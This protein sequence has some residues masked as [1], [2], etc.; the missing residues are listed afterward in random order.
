[1]GGK[2]QNSHGQTQGEAGLM[3]GREK[4]GNTL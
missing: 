2:I 4:L 1:M 3:N